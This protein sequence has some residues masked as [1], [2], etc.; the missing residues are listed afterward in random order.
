VSGKRSLLGFLHPDPLAHILAHIVPAG[1]KGA[2]WLDSS[3][4]P[5]DM[6]AALTAAENTGLLDCPIGIRR[7]NATPISLRLVAFRLPTVKA[8]EARARARRAAKREA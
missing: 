5:F 8:E 1:W 4:K 6:L 2:R 7:Q 3:G